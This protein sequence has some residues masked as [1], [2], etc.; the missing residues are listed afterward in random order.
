MA[1]PV[2][3]ET[4]DDFDEM[5]DVI[6]AQEPYS[7]PEG[8][9][10]VEL[11]YPNKLSEADIFA[12]CE[13]KFVT[14]DKNGMTN[15][16]DQIAPNSLLFSDN[17]FGLGAL[18]KH[19]RGK[20][21]LIYTDPPFATGTAF[22][23]RKQ[24]HAYEDRFGPAT[25]VEF[26]RRRL[27]L[28]RELLA[29]DGSIYLHIGHQMLFHLKLTMDEVFGRSNFRNLIVRKKC[30]SKNY[31][32][33]Q[34]PN[35]N[36]YILFY[37][38]SK[39]WKWNPPGV[40]ASPEWIAREYGK[41]DEKGRYKL[42][43]IHAPGVRNGE[44]GKEWCG[45]LP[46][47]GKHWQF[48]PAKLDELDQKGEIYRSRTG[49]PRRKVYLEEDKQLQ[50][51]DYWDQFRDPHHQSI[52]ISGYPTEKN[53]E[54]L[55]TIVSASSDVGD[56]VLDPFAGSGT[57]LQ[58]ANDGHRQW[59]GIDESP[60]AAEAAVTRLRHG[61]MPMGDYVKR[62]VA[63]VLDLFGDEHS[64]AEVKKPIKTVTEASF[65]FVVESQLYESDKKTI[66]RLAKL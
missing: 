50:L 61:V 1:K 18:L 20:V 24:Q 29:N 26:M 38:K 13:S 12:S 30:S 57:T 16:V 37:S 45:M 64:N 5:A 46:P 11:V 58:A 32:K 8:N 3:S 6:Y 41:S 27:I 54:M 48:T 28:M 60:T 10:Q 39:Q 51:T 56:L 49:N 21:N 52:A 53:L 66:H 65:S 36:D 23:S 59:I 17:F 31:T 62:N 2:L 63:P 44:T 22:H 33:H 43:P 47:A 7:L 55:R 4:A 35:L 25:Y 19:Y 15:P 34:Y 14:V 9:E 40:P 42:V